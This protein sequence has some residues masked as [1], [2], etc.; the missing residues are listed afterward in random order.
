MTLRNK[1]VFFRRLLAISAALWLWAAP[2]L[3][4]SA[5][6]PIVVGQTDDMF[7]LCLTAENGQQLYYASIDPESSVLQTDLNGDGVADLAVTTRMGAANRGQ[8][9]FLRSG[10]FYVPVKRVGSG[11]DA[12]YNY[13]GSPDGRYI[14]T[15][16]NNGYAGAL[17][18]DSL[19]TWS[20]TDLQLLRR[21]VS[22]PKVETE[23]VDNKLI[24]TEYQDVLVI[25]VWDYAQGITQ[26][27]LLFQAEVNLYDENTLRTT[28]SAV[29]V[30]MA[31]PS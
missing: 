4:Q 22:Q 11:E 18:D 27:N 12:F 10:D 2:A 30:L 25:R 29:Q 15:N 6:T 7:L 1:C 31:F 5:F 14:V 28:L 19:Y 16:T 9:F 26:G 3:C 23:V 13:T 20:G 8:E 17:F 24:T 21:A